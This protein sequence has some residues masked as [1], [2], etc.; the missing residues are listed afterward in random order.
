MRTIHTLWLL[1]L[2][3]NF[4]DS[5]KDDNWIDY[6]LRNYELNGY[7]K[8]Y[9]RVCLARVFTRLCGLSLSHLIRHSSKH[10]RQKE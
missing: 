3:L 7:G 10:S 1:S 9:S 2:R 4:A 6:R 5:F 8:V